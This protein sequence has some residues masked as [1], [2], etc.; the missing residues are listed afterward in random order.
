MNFVAI[1][2]ETANY[3]PASACAMGIVVVE[4]GKIT[5]ERYRLIRPFDMTFSWRNIQVHGI[6]P[7]DVENEPEFY[8]YWKSIRSYLSRG[9]IIAHNAAFDTKVLKSVLELYNLEIPDF[10]YQCSVKIARR[11]W[12]GWRS[13]SLD[14]VARKLGFTFKHHHALEDSQMCANVVLA[15]A[16][17]L[18]INS[19][20]DLND[21]LGLTPK[22]L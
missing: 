6:R 1:D 3:N 13:Y 18:G 17:E 7:E 21:C 4:N 16:Q 9:Q 11:T 2:F 10:E 12:Q 8:R 5:D 14:N 22:L 15:A 19:M 20:Q